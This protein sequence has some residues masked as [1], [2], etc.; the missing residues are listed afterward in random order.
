MRWPAWQRRWALSDPSAF[1]NITRRAD[2]TIL[3]HAESRWVEAHYEIAPNDAPLLAES[4]G[5]P[6]DLIAEGWRDCGAGNG[7]SATLAWFGDHGI[8]FRTAFVWMD[9]ED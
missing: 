7:P 2:G 4:L 8:P 9:M 3:V 5:V 1:T 6:I